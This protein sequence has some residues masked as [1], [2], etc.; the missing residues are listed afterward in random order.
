MPTKYKNTYYTNDFND[1]YN[2]FYG[3]EYDGTSPLAQTGIMTEADLALGKR[4]L[5]TYNT[6][7]QLT[8]AYESGVR[9]ETDR[10]GQLIQ[11]S[12]ERYNRELQA[13]KDSYERNAQDLLQNYRTAGQSLEKDRAYAKQGAS[14]SYDKLKKYLPEMAK[15]QGLGGLGV[16]GSTALQAYNS[17]MN[18]VGKID[19][20]YLDGKTE[21]EKAY[22][23]NKSDL[24]ST[25]EK[26][27]ADTENARI[28]AESGYNNSLNAYLS[29]A[30]EK[31][32]ADMY[33]SD[34]DEN[35]NLLSDNVLKEYKD[36][37]EDF[38]AGNYA[39][40]YDLIAASG[41]RTYDEMRDILKSYMGKVSTEQMTQL[42]AAAKV[43]ANANRDAEETLDRDNALTVGIG[44]LDTLLASAQES[45][46]Y[47]SFSSYLESV[48][49]IVGENTYEAYRSMIN[50]NPNEADNTEKEK[51]EEESRV[52]EGKEYVSYGG[53][54]YQIKEKLDSGAN[55]IR[56]ND[57]FTNQLKKLG[58]TNPYDK[59]IPNGLTLGLLCDKKGSNTSSSMGR[60]YY[61]Y[62]TYYNG[63]WYV[64]ENMSK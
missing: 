46:D 53:K 34:K 2:H 60:W 9:T 56:K 58:F 42:V 17:Y 14:I 6:Q 52:L 18:N 47:G 1:W 39:E 7:K 20:E 45:G 55:E 31:Y 13:Q 44:T 28:D 40:A 23:S 15:A 16:S 24:D 36:A 49:D 29:S 62:V 41:Y 5:S 10:Y 21:L 22:M 57:S 33:V 38:F 43:Q 8:D 11:S 54:E 50:N 27:R 12:N 51:A 37:E 30:R 48:K 3:D 32:G 59:N 4:L 35:G 25:Y 63:E 64:S 26:S 19:G 61:R